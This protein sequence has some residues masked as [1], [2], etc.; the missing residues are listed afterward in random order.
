MLNQEIF[1]KGVKEMFRLGRMK[2]RKDVKRE[3]NLLKQKF[4]TIELQPCYGDA[5]LK[6][7]ENDLTKLWEEIYN[8]EKE[9]NHFAFPIF[10]GL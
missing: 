8:L 3:I 4:K 6:Q 1:I 7:K 10:T 5:D 9:I 2:E